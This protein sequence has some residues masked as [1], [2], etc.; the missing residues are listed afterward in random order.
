MAAAALVVL[1]P[2]AAAQKRDGQNGMTAMRIKLSSVF[3]DDQEKAL[4]FYSRVLG[5]E[6]KQDIPMGP[7]R[8]LTVVSPAEPNGTELVL[9]PN[10][11]PAAETYQKA[12]HEA[13]IPA[14]A[15]EV[16]D[17]DAEFE[18]LKGLDVVFTMKPTAMGSVTQAIFDDACGNLIQIYQL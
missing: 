9:E 6:K 8:W 4:D 16:D 13:G 1:S 7:A 14:T 10:V 12:I 2:H 5:F 18:R 3:V 17:I 15:F 11:F